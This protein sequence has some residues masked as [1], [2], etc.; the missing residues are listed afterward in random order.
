MNYAPEITKSAGFTPLVGN[1]VVMLWNFLTS[2]VA[3]PCATRFPPRNLYIVGTLIASLACLLNGIPVYPGLLEDDEL[4]HVLSGSGILIFI[5][6]FQI[7]MGP[8]FYMLCVEL[9]PL[10]YRA[11]GCA[12]TNFTQYVMNIMVNFGYPVIVVALSGGLDANQDKGQAMMFIFFGFVGLISVPP[13]ITFLYPAPLEV[14]SQGQNK[15]D[16][17]SSSSSNTS[18]QSPL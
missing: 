1:F 9:F 12:F 11:R 15:S 17:S 3:I 6:A 8:V 16:S 14:V 18:V 2:I 10:K 13:M 5:A 7:A 4:R